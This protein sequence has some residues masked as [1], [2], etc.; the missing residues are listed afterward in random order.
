MSDSISRNQRRILGAVASLA[1]KTTDGFSK[2]DKVL[3]LAITSAGEWRDSCEDVLNG[4]YEAD[5]VAF[6]FYRALCDMVN[7]S[8]TPLLLG[9]GDLA[10]PAAPRYT[11]VAMS[12]H[13]VAFLTL[14]DRGCK[15]SD[16]LAAD[17]RDEER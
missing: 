7:A 1:L 12:P 15:S 3:R 13:G 9:K 6:G 4:D 10:G 11:E 2:C 8:T 14:E 17:E 5:Q 16:F